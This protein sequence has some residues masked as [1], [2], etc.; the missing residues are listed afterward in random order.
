MPRQLDPELEHRILDA[1][2]RL[3]DEGGEEAVTMRAVAERAG[4]HTPR[5]YLRLKDKG[6][7]LRALRSAALVRWLARM[8]GTRSLR[9]GCRRYL[10][11]AAERPSDYGLLWGPG[12]RDRIA[13]GDGAR[14]MSVLQRGLARDLG[15]EPSVHRALALSIWALLHG[16]VSLQEEFGDATHWRELADA[17]IDACE[18]VAGITAPSGSTRTKQPSGRLA[19]GGAM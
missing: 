5:I 8:Q 3:W 9:D 19:T 6:T 2:Q 12:F 18:R 16:T 1:A 14:A 13:P 17:C 11:F 7:L 10:D 4:T 15:G